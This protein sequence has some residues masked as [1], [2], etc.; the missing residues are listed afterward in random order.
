MCRVVLPLAAPGLAATAICVHRGLERVPVRADVRER[1]DARR[2]RVA[3]QSFVGR[4]DTDWGAIMAASVLFTLPVVS[5]SCCVAP[6][7][8]RRHGRRRAVTRLHQ[9]MPAS[10]S[11]TSATGSCATSPPTWRPRRRGFTGVLHT[12]SENDL[13]YYRD[14]MARIVAVS[15]D[16]GLEVQVGPWGVGRTFGGE[17]ESRFVAAQPHVGQVLADGRPCRPAAPTSRA[18][19]LRAR[20]GRR[21]GRDRRRPHLLGRAALGPPGPL[22]LDAAT[23]WG[24]LCDA[25][26]SR[27]PRPL[28]RRMPRELT[29]GGRS[30]SARTSWSTSSASSSPTSTRIG[31]QADGLPAAARRRARTASTTGSRSRAL[32][33]LRH[34]GDRPVL[35]RSRAGRAVRAASTPA[36][37]PSWR[38]STT[39]RRR[40]GSRASGSRAEDAA[41]STPPCARPRGGGRGPVDLGLRGLRAHDA[42]SAARDPAA[43]LGRALR[44]RA[45]RRRRARARPRAA[46]P[47]LAELDLRADAR[48]VVRALNDEDAVVAR[49]GGATPGA[50]SRRAVDAIVARLRAR[51]PHP[52]R[53][54]HGRPDGRCS[55][56]PRRARRSGRR[57]RSSRSSAGGTRLARRPAGEAGEDDAD[58]GA[59]RP[60]GRSGVGRRT[61]RWSASRARRAG[62]PTSLGAAARGRARRCGDRRRSSAPAARELGGA[63]RRRDR[64]STSAPRS[65]RARPG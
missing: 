3:L 10:A 9:R 52:R 33:G 13:T 50:T 53:R 1:G 37:S 56:P 24:C 6:P 43:R 62:R 12:F 65:S 31:G 4:G 60:R 21:G 27:V 15:H 54:R 14:T 20:V 28:R 40:S 51:S 22:R 49:R 19:R 48:A 23:R 32:P 30:R 36:A 58:A 26:A 42:R 18:A 47:R 35:G 5:S 11:R 7:A 2:C 41:T 17:A 44:C 34:A 55:T 25:A 38:P 46:S 45:G 16:A 61:T 29:A 8:D 63:R 39:S 57:S 64:A 59:A